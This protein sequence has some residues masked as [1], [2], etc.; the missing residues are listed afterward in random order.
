[1]V[2]RGEF[3][4]SGFIVSDDMAVANIAATHHYAGSPT[5]AAADAL[6]SGCDLELDNSA[7]DAAFPTLVKSVNNGRVNRSDVELAV[8]RVLTQ[9]FVVGDIDPPSLDPYSALNESD[10]YA[11][12]SLSVSWCG[13]GACSGRTRMMNLLP[14]PSSLPPTLLGKP[15]HF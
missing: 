13:K 7:S 15:S 6:T 11:P 5:G 12:A 8:S 1:M 9:R 3:N 4:W 10:I 14:N 2:A